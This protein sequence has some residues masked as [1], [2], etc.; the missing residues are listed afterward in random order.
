MKKCTLILSCCIFL[1]Q[2]MS[3]GNNPCSA[4]Q[5]PANMVGFQSITIG[6]S[7]SSEEDPICGDYH[8]ADEWFSFTAPPGGDVA[9]QLLEGSITNAAFVLYSG[10]CNDLEEI[11]CVADYLCGTESMPAHFFEG[12]VEGATYYLRI[13][14]EESATSGELELIIA[15]PSGNPYI[16][17][18]NAVSTSFQGMSNCIQLTEQTTG[19]VGCA[20]YPEEVDFNEP[21][22]HE[23]N[24]YLGT[25]QGQAGADGMAIIYQVNG[26][27]IC[28][29]SGG[30][31]G[32][33]GIDNSWT[34]EFD[35]YQNWVPY[36]DPPEDHTAISLNGDLTYHPSGPVGLGVLSDG[37]FHDVICSWDPTDQRFRVWFDGLLV[38]DIV[39]DIVN[40]VFDG[41]NM[42]HWGVSAS[43]GG[44][45]NEHILCFDN[46]E[47]ENLLNSYSFQEIWI[48]EGDAYYAGGDYQTEEG[49]YLDIY[50]AANGCDS[51]V[52]TDLSLFPREEPT[53]LEIDLCPGEQFLF[54]GVPLE[55]TGSYEF[56]L[57]D[58]YGCD[59]L[60]VIEVF[61]PIHEGYLIQ[62][63]PL[64][65]IQEE[66]EIAV[67]LFTEVDEV[68][69]SWSSFNGNIVS[70]HDSSV[71]VVD[72]EG[73]YSLEMYFYNE[74]VLCG[75]YILSETVVREEVY[76]EENIIEE[77]VL[78][79]DGETVIL[80]ASNSQ[81]SDQFAWETISG[82]E[83]IGDTDQSSIEINGP[84]IYQLTLTHEYTGCKK[85]I[86]LEVEPP[87]GVPLARINLLD[88]L[89]CG[90]S[91]IW[92]DAEGSTEDEHIV[93]KWEAENDRLLSIPD[94][95][96]VEVEWEGTV[97]LSVIDTMVQCTTTTQVELVF[98]EDFLTAELWASDTLNCE[99]PEVELGA[100]VFDNHFR[101]FFQWKNQQGNILYESDSL[102]NLAV[103]S[104]GWY[105]F[106]A[107]D[108]TG[109]CHFAD[110]IEVVEHLDEP[111]IDLGEN[112]DF[113][114]STLTV[115][116]GEE[117]VFSDSSLAFMWY[118]P[119][120]Q[121][122][123]EPDQQLI[124][125]ADPGRYFLEVEHPISKCTFVDS[126]DVMDNRFY[127]EINLPDSV[128]LNCD[129]TEKSVVPQVLSS[130]DY[131]FSWF[132]LPAD[133]A[134]SHQRE[135]T[136]SEEGSYRLEVIN[137]ET[138]CVVDAFME[139]VVD[140]AKIEFSVL[141]E[142]L[143]N[144]AVPQSELEVVP[145]DPAAMMEVTWRDEEGM[146]I[147]EGSP[148]LIVEAGG[149]YFV[150]VLNTGN[151]CTQNDSI[152]I[153][154]DFVAP[155]F[156]LNSVDTLNCMD[157]LA[158]IHAWP[159]AEFRDV[160]FE[161]VGPD[162]Q[163]LDDEGDPF[164]ITVGEPGVYTLE[165]T[166]RESHCRSTDSFLIE[167]FFNSANFEIVMEDSVINC[168]R[169]K[170]EVELN[171]EG[172]RENLRI[173]WE[174]QSGEILDSLD[175]MDQAVFYRGNSFLIRA[176]DELSLCEFER[177]FTIEENFNY[178]N[179]I[180]KSDGVLSCSRD[181]VSIR[182]EF[183]D[184][185]ENIDIRW[186][187]ENGERV[188]LSGQKEI[189]AGSPGFY[190]AE[191]VDT[192][193][194]CRIEEWIEVIRMG[195]PIYQVG[196]RVEPVDCDGENGAVIIE[197]IEG[198]LPPFL[199]GLNELEIEGDRVEFYPLLAGVYEIEIVDSLGCKWEKTVE[200]EKPLPLELDL[201]EQYF[202]VEGEQVELRPQINKDESDLVE[203]YWDPASH[204]S[205]YSCLFPIAFPPHTMS[206]HLWISDIDGCIAE[207]TT[208]IVV[209]IRKDIFI[210]NAFS[211]HNRDGIN[212]Y[213][214]PFTKSDRVESIA[215]LSIFNRWGEK[216]FSAGDLDPEHP[217]HG[218]DGL[219]D[220]RPSPPGVYIYQIEVEWKDGERIFY[221]GEFTLIN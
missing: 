164:Q 74:G 176:I 196:L 118:S 160:L 136:V 77:G 99:I 150:E 151:H 200:L 204:L 205:C 149:I 93:Y 138:D 4:T 120:G 83:I 207:A 58:Q 161:W 25:V 183:E 59:S 134:F 214:F 1:T 33:Q 108:D 15:H 162:G 38:H 27:P 213:F 140:T 220:G 57:T 141:G 218:W 174:L 41:Q 185:H 6:N 175:N 202:V 36:I 122:V 113:Y 139:V 178:P 16:T 68:L 24:I 170:I 111:F 105:Y 65:C 128:Y 110:S 158:T 203:I 78:G 142:R 106:R 98:D 198:G 51:F 92:L 123:S 32:F 55:E 7:G 80:D 191:A 197:G 155:E 211:P 52:T 209:E 219:F 84:G 221:S 64:T 81:N 130:G 167:G 21:F 114:C 37:E 14:N 143:I 97:I 63:G 147:K 17:T 89:R 100:D 186:S 26:I 153:E 121:I 13:W 45:V 8:G 61:V 23:F 103:E 173:S 132:L 67:E 116:L 181:S 129:Q 69:F 19:Q 201:P 159:E 10:S 104:G 72:A 9:I 11:N 54:H 119:D 172:D 28:G 48:C 79:C 124:E 126:I 18:G 193:S 157:S 31:I 20:W 166:D 66:V 70:G 145:N 75:P 199:I 152:R 217:E 107:Y 50:T 195:E 133:S 131:Q 206:Y 117:M 171:F 91:S 216:V 156:Q 43:T 95:F 187:D 109:R 115:V 102:E 144:C 76:P 96:S 86:Q 125:A 188:D 29:L 101:A 73:H 168:L 127:P 40:D 71:V 53:V 112:L 163:W 60:V 39:Y 180:A 49:I 85:E 30:G 82:S 210:P 44:S 189:R 47:L 212:D 148:T 192:I 42:A 177:E 90:Q 88:S 5:L 46:I 22:E 154:S 87:P 146:A 215:H 184:F 165:V 194:G 190:L 2:W 12:L 179:F 137:T 56:L 94:S 182:M 208:E 135:I 3:G 62:N 169:E 35:T 34:I